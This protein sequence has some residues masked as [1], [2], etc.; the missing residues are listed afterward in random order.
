VDVARRAGVSQATVSLVLSGKAPGRISDATAE[1]VRH[2]ARELGY[3][4]N[5]AAR[6]LKSGAARAVG[7]VVPDVTNPVFGRVLRGAQRAAWDAG[8]AVAL[9]DTAND[10]AWRYTSVDALLALPVDGFVVFAE[11]P[12]PALTEPGAP[13]TVMIEGTATG[14]PHVRLDVEDG[15]DQALAHL[16][17]LGHRRI[18]HLRSEIDQ[19]TF[20]RRIRRYEA[21]LRDRGVDPADMAVE[22][23]GFSAREAIA[24][25]RALL[26]QGRAPTAVICD[27]D[28][29]AAGLVVAAREAGLR[30]PG[31]LSVVGFDDLDVATVSDPSLTT[32]RIDAEALGAAGFG[33]L[34]ARLE[35]RS[36]RS[37][38]LGVEL[39][40]RESTGRPADQV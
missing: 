32:V 31:D 15:V 3:R 33:L 36:P 26:A 4:P 16:D 2:A 13:P 1:A 28:I 18:G 9:V 12:P 38:V 14:L 23:G 30:V 22:P 10:P 5:A 39:V 37:R 6:A 35:G 25:G 40:V 8:H 34:R 27:D 29:L 7:L 20:R 17:G 24:A 11:A 21:H 19:D